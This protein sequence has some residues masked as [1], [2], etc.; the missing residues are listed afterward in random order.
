MLRLVRKGGK[1][2]KQII[3]KRIIFI[4]VVG[5]L[6]VG[7]I[8]LGITLPTENGLHI[9]ILYPVGVALLF[10]LLLWFISSKMKNLIDEAEK[11]RQTAE[12]ASKAKTTFLANMS[13]EIRTPMNAIL[14]ITEIQLQRE[15][16]DAETKIAIE[17]IFISGDMLLGII[18]DIL[19]LSKIEAGKLELFTDKYEI[20][21]LVSDTIQL[22]L[23]RVGSKR[24]DFE[25][26][27]DEGIPGLLLGDELRVKQILNNLLSN[28]FKYTAE[29]KVSLAIDMEPDGNP[30]NGIVLVITVGDT[31]QGMTEE[32][33][34]NL[35][36]E[37]T[38]FNT[39]TNR[40]TE[41]TGLGMSITKKLI[42]LMNGDITVKSKKG[43]GSTFTVRLPQG[44]I[45]GEKL[46][47]E[48]ADNL[49]LFRT[50][51][52]MQMRRTQITRDAMPYG[53]ILV[54]D[55]VETN[56]YVV[57]GLLMPY[58]LRISSASSGY[59]AIE[60][61]KNGNVY[62]IIFMDHMMPEIDGIEATKRIRE[63]GYNQPIVA[64]TANAVSG[65]AD[66]FLGN[67][68][69]DFI[70]KPI[71]LRQMNMLL[72][73]MI[74]DKQPLE[75]I[76]KARKDSAAKKEMNILPQNNDD[77]EFIKVF[78][79]DAE[80]SLTTLEELIKVDEWH[81]HEDDMRAYIIHI[82]TIKTSLA[83]IGKLDLSAVALK[84]EQAARNKILEITL[85]ETPLFFRSLRT[86][87]D[88]LEST[89][90]ERDIITVPPV[91]NREITGIDIV[92][93][94][95]QMNNDEAA[96]VQVL[97]SYTDNVRAMLT[98]IQTFD[99]KEITK[100]QVTVHGIKGTSLYVYAEPVGRKAEALEKAAKAGD[101]DYINENNPTFL[102]TAI[103]LI[104]D[105][106]E[107][108]AE[109]ETEHP[110]LIKPKPDEA[111]LKSVLDACK[112][113]DMDDLDT[114]ME[115]VGRYQYDADDGLA[116]WL[117]ESV[118][119]MELTKIAEK[120]AYLEAE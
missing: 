1:Y 77:P 105:L 21:S 70:S 7:L 46:G 9:I 101:V 91:L 49:R 113:F 111:I 88:E 62:D 92:K 34:K 5:V 83:N 41:G 52:T 19:D 20:A 23:M 59:A 58:E 29:G 2:M 117:R 14:G 56:I 71:D 110:R 89:E 31:G 11:Q 12:E 45:N 4:A 106:D 103:K 104:D 55:D 18:N 99:E 74:R 96:Y 85:P 90:N 100:Y 28:A 24:I 98:S 37:Y 78:T 72:N 84:L 95:R 115:E 42:D 47:K 50:S 86:Y 3:E 65:Q 80:K 118:N 36:T 25:M 51:N 57:K 68:F 114:A 6:V 54:V 102:T 22:N 38:R 120:L 61:I 44:R 8:I 43:V 15:T 108:L 93:G 82:H 30:D 73:K 109:Y 63:L 48:M 40:S 79:R 17:R 66:I 33:V 94:F 32:H 69:D 112:R 97:R 60:K 35:F 26:H 13:H 107:M 75:V 53:H 81:R 64:L 116:D 87:L 27:I 10:V 76:E 39:E 67:G 16:L 119:N